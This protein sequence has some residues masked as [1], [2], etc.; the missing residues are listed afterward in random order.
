ML[1]F[2]SRK[3]YEAMINPVLGAIVDQDRK[4][5]VSIA[6]RT[7][8]N[9]TKRWKETISTVSE[10]LKKQD[11]IVWYLRGARVNV[12][13]RLPTH[14]V[15]Q[16]KLAEI[17]RDEELDEHDLTNLEHYLS[18]PIRAIQEYRFD[19]KPSRE[20]FEDFRGFEDEWRKSLDASL[21]EQGKTVIDF[22]NGWTWQNLERA[23]C[24]KEA[25]AMGHCGNAPRADS[26]DTIL[27]LRKQIE[28]PNGPRWEPKLTFIL[29]LDGYLSEMKGKANNKPEAK[30]HP[31]IIA[32]LRLPMIKGIVGG[33][34]DPENNFAL[35]DLT[36]T[37]REDL[38]KQNP[39]LGNLMEI[40]DHGGMSKLLRNRIHS[41]LRE[42][43]FEYHDLTDEEC[44]LEEDAIN[45]FFR[46]NNIDDT[47]YLV[48]TGD[49]D[50]VNSVTF[51]DKDTVR[52]AFDEMLEGADGALDVLIERIVQE[53]HISH[54][55][56]L[57]AFLHVFPKSSQR[58]LEEIKIEAVRDAKVEIT[59]FLDSISP[60]YRSAQFQHDDENI[61]LV[62][63][64]GAFIN[65]L[66]AMM[67]Q[68]EDDNQ[69]SGILQTHD[70]DWLVIDRDYDNVIE[71]DGDIFG[72]NLRATF[73]Q[74]LIDLFEVEDQ[75]KFDFMRDD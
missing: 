6:D 31:M 12:A 57:D 4:L 28:G 54:D 46:N 48:S 24:S 51:L 71:P 74:R 3:T 34:H 58:I 43:G 44:I 30:Y 20:V 27:S 9:V 42:Y 62:V 25:D 70:G 35:S 23:Y 67:E 16:T 65:D 66:T 75:L 63:P 15:D 1:L 50:S 22:H 53:L 69:I 29:T 13:N 17:N 47:V 40:Y 19:K 33:G 61:R 39:H 56:A 41:T 72:D 18:L 38:V 7:K 55:D 64:V 11:I 2:E 8:E 45:S 68:Y 36:E 21:D 60:K 49:I 37:E 10:K 5:S 73:V 14:L 26:G 59:E 52:E 32:L